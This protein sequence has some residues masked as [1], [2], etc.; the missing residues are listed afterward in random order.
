MSMLPTHAQIE[1]WVNTQISDGGMISLMGTHAHLQRDIPAAFEAFTLLLHLSKN[2]PIQA[3]CEQ[4]DITMPQ[5]AWVPPTADSEG[6]L[7]MVAHMPPGLFGDIALW[8]TDLTRSA[9]LKTMPGAL[10]LP[11]SVAMANDGMVLVPEWAA[12]FYPHQQH[13]NCFPLL[14][15][16]SMLNQGIVPPD[17]TETALHRLG[18]Y[19]L[20][21][22]AAQA[23]L[24]TMRAEA[25]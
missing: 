12:A 11:F 25:I 1:Q 6:T 15:F 3:A 21:V 19:R 16:E 23:N 4:I 8:I 17:W 20:P 2:L 13:G 14:V 22:D 18:H 9:T 7:L 24:A 5:L 10:A